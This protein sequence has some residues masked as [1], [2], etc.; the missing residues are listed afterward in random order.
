MA[1]YSFRVLRLINQHY[2]KNSEITARVT[3]NKTYTGVND[4]RNFKYFHSF[5]FSPHLQE[6]IN[7]SVLKESE[8]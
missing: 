7:L 3:N 6:F 8:L 5:I 1:N 4:F 2:N